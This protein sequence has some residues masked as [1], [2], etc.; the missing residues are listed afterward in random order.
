MFHDYP[1]ILSTANLQEILRLSKNS[2]LDLLQNKQI[3][4]FRKG[5]KYLIPKA[6]VIDYIENACELRKCGSAAV[7]TTS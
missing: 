7:E 6:C 4:H 2:V 1:D 5:K 3:K